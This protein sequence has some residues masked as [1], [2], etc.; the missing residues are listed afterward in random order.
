MWSTTTHPNGLVNRW[1]TPSRIWDSTP[2]WRQHRVV[3]ANAHTYGLYIDN[4]TDLCKEPT[5]ATNGCIPPPSHFEGDEDHLVMSTINLKKRSAT[6]LSH[7]DEDEDD[8]RVMSM[9]N[10]KKRN[11]TY[12]SRTKAD[13][14]IQ[15]C[16][17]SIEGMT[18]SSCVAS[19]ERNLEKVD[20]I[21]NYY[22]H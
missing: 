4:L 12:K 13:D 19:I 7:F 20:G 17:F 10:L 21:S 14:P 1:P 6:Y 5:K 16:S 9:I 8:D 15:R 18:C 3:F 11:A 22:D 2:N